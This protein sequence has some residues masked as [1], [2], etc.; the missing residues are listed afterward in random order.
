M[1]IWQLNSIAGNKLKSDIH[2]DMGCFKVLESR[3]DPQMSTEE[4]TA[5]H[6]QHQETDTKTLTFFPAALSL[7]VSLN[8]MKS[9]K[10]Q[11][12]LKHSF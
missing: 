3:K 11:I 8:V 4:E 1:F 10:Q 9:T 2:V 6:I 7:S 5:S 12:S